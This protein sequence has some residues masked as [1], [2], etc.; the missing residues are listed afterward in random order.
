MPVEIE[1]FNGKQTQ[2]N[3]SVSPKAP[4]RLRPA[5]PGTVPKGF[6]AEL[7]IDGIPYEI[8]DYRGRPGHTPGA[9]V[10][11]DGVEVKLSPGD[12]ANAINKNIFRWT[13]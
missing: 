5:P 10:K 4:I 6:D 3:L 1:T 7:A 8:H 13:P 2:M 11:G 9:I 12:H